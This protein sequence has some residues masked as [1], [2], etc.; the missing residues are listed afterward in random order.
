[1][2]RSTVFLLLIASVNIFIT[3]SVAKAETQNI[4]TLPRN[5][6]LAD[7]VMRMQVE[8]R[9]GNGYQPIRLE[10]QSKKATF[11]RD[12]N[13]QVFITPSQNNR[14]QLSY[15]F[16]KSFVLPEGV[17]VHTE[18]ILV[19]RYFPWR[20]VSA[21]IWED[22]EA[23]P[24][25]SNQAG[26]SLEMQDVSQHHLV[27]VMIGDS[28][29]KSDQKYVPDIRTLNTVL[30]DGPLPEDS[31][32]KR[33]STV[34]ATNQLR[35]TQPCWVQYRTFTGADAD[36]NWLWYSQLDIVIA[37]VDKLQELNTKYPQKYAAL[38]KWIASGGTLW[39]YGTDTKNSFPSL[40]KLRLQ[41]ISSG[42]LLGPKQAARKLNLGSR[43]ET[44]RLYDTGSEMKVSG[45]SGKMRRDVFA[46]LRSNSHPFAAEEPIADILARIEFG[47]LGIGQVILIDDPDPFPGSFQFWKSVEQISNGSIVEDKLDWPSRNGV[48][49]SLGSSSYWSWVIPSV[50]QPPVKTFVLLNILFALLIG[51]VCYYFLRNRSRL[52][53]L[54]F[55]APAAA[56]FVTCSLFVYAIA[57]DGLGTK[58][59]VRQI[60]W[61]DPKSKY[62]V[63]QSRHTYFN[64]TGGGP[65]LVFSDQTATYLVSNIELENR[66]YYFRSNSDRYGTVSSDSDQQRFSAGFL[67]PREQVQYI[68]VDVDKADQ[69]TLSFEMKSTPPTVTS[70]LE[71]PITE[72]VVCDQGGQHWKASVIGPGETVDLAKTGPGAAL[73]IL[74]SNVLPPK[75]ES[76]DLNGNSRYRKY[77]SIDQYSLLE[78]KLESWVNM[79]R[80]SFIG[81]M[82][83]DTNKLGIES[84]SMIRSSHI[85]MGELP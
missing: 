11:V 70:T 78:R 32:N 8:H 43:N 56:L 54:Y 61:I 17:A 26:F 37:S 16:T 21:R 55:A 49:I 63:Q 74:D 75:L 12:H 14:G 53:V 30:G 45:G 34:K 18:E 29:I 31:K 42:R 44:G 84:A 50:G 4:L 59:R 39:V 66:R 65:G 35:E 9:G 47:T 68:C 36:E 83:L 82:D 19:P 24:S 22:G 69:P 6:A 10:F 85:I 2:I 48:D 7:F 73:D 20:K 5:R 64:S 40:E 80:N 28:G 33:Q 52:Y 27:G 72:F 46:K 38:E 71:K 1:M 23:I 15:E 79:P 60:T 51:P 58:A 81:K 57:K 67:P 3:E 13:V 62:N 41:Q 25:G 77:S 76:P